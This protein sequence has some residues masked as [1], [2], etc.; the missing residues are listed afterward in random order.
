MDPVAEFVGLVA[1]KA[2]CS[3]DKVGDRGCGVTDEEVDSG[4]KK[5]RDMEKSG[6]NWPMT[7]LSEKRRSYSSVVE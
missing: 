1:D 5:F 2:F 4:W 3:V 6:A 7:S